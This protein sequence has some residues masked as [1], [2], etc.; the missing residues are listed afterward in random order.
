M[1]LSQEQDLSRL[2]GAT[3]DQSQTTAFLLARDRVYDQ[4]DL[5]TGSNRPNDGNNRGHGGNNGPRDRGRVSQL[6][7]RW[8]PWGSSNW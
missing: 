4:E 7:W 3:H 5:S 6:A 1:L 8:C 2:H